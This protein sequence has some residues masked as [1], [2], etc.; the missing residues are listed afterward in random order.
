MTTWLLASTHAAPWGIGWLQSVLTSAGLDTTAWP[1]H[2]AWLVQLFVICCVAVHVAEWLGPR[3]IPEQPPG[4]FQ[5]GWR[6][7]VVGAVV[8]GPALAYLTDVVA[9][10]L[11]LALR[12]GSGFMSAWPAWAQF[13]SVFLTN[14]LG[15]YWLHRW[16]HESDLLWRLHRVHH[17]A[18]RMSVMTNF[19]M[20]VLEA[21]PKYVL[22]ILPFRLLGVGAGVFLVYSAI[23]LIKGFWHHA[24]V[25][26]P[27][28]KA[29][30]V[31]NTAEQHWWHHSTQR[32]GQYANYG[33]VLS[34]WDRMFGTFYWPQG[35]WPK[36]I[37]VYG[38]DQYPET[39]LGRLVSVVHPDEAFSAKPPP[40]EER[41]PETPEL[42]REPAG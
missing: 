4:P 30:L 23:D 17:T 6:A 11:V 26:T 3:V 27:V 39:Y 24:N 38:V 19:R 16:H 31:L 8:D 18:T 36:R 15:R 25:R 34:I 33:S 40:V 20:H 13:A 10:S 2:T 7:D 32:R 22:L 41:L 14:D 29:N 35:R 28:G 21:V 1:W 9:L 12:A 5:T 37:G 42:C